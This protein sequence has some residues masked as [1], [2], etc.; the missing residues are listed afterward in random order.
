[1]EEWDPIGVSDIP[2]AADE[3]DAYLGGIY[4]LIARGGNAEEPGSY[5]RAIEVERMEL[6]TSDSRRT[7]AAASLLQLKPLCDQ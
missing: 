7:R 3:Y 4:D 1:M 2:E 5:L 6:E